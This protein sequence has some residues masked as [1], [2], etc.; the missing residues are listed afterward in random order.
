MRLQD[1]EPPTEQAPP[2]E[3]VQQYDDDYRHYRAGQHRV[4]RLGRLDAAPGLR[5]RLGRAGRLEFGARAAIVVGTVA[6][7]VLAGWLVAPGLTSDRSAP[8]SA[9]GPVVPAATTAP[10][11]SLAIGSPL[12]TSD[13]VGA[14]AA[15]PFELTY[16]KHR[17]QNY[18]AYLPERRTSQLAVVVVHGGGW[19]AGDAQAVSAFNQRLYDA[20]IASF[21][22]NY[23]LATDARWPAQREDLASALADIRSHARTWGFNVNTV[24]V[25]GISA[26]GHIALDLASGPRAN[27]TCG[28]VSYSGPTSMDL[29]LEDAGQG[30]KQRDLAAAVRKLTPTRALRASATVPHTPGP[31]DAPALLFAGQY[32]WVDARNTSQ[33]GAAYAGVPLEVD[34][35]VLPGEQRHASAYALTVPSVWNRTMD[36]LTRNCA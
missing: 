29:V 23:R 36:F 24:A 16:G 17:R 4:G 19:V 2:G 20:G 21:S 31:D 11:P 26:G 6:A 12:A 7:A 14:T 22:I 8:T 18:L 5:R 32:D 33:Y 9:V 30:P 1:V 3:L 28:V 25:M 13:A 35:V 15:I 27:E 10:S 34:A